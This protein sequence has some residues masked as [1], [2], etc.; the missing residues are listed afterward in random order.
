MSMVKDIFLEMPS[1]FWND[2]FVGKIMAFLW[3]SVLMM[4]VGLI[5][6]VC[7]EVADKAFLTYKDGSAVVIQHRFDPAH[8]ETIMQ[9]MIVGKTTMMI[10]QTT[11]YPD[12]YYLELKIN[13]LTGEMQV[14]KSFY[15]EVKDNSEV[16]VKYSKNRLSN[17][18]TFD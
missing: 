6:F 5:F 15:D 17:G 7:F 12:R 4:L 10:P 14:N 13:D 1:D 8:S 2:G 3:L 11:N 18:L 9:T 16:N